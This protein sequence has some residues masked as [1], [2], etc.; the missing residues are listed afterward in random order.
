MIVSREAYIYALQEFG[1]K[2][3]TETKASDYDRDF[4]KW[5]HHYKTRF[6]KMRIGG[7]WAV[8]ELVRLVR[9]DP[10]FSQ[11]G[12]DPI[13][14]RFSEM[15]SEYAMIAHNQETAW[16]FEGAREAADTIMWGVQSCI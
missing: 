14:R 15:M 5:R 10:Y 11:M 1:R 7:M 3:Y 9:A 2:N 12:P 8:N 13:L 4:P 6:E 16:I